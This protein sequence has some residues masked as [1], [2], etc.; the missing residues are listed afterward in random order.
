MDDIND[1]ESLAQGSRYYEQLKIGLDMNDFGSWAH[2]SKCYEQL[3]SV[4]DLNYSRSWVEDAM[5]NQALWM[6]WMT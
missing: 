3:K 4:S 6:I 2:D 5:N 1:S